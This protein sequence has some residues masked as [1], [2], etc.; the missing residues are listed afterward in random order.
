MVVFIRVRT[1]IWLATALVIFGAH[2]K[3]I[4]AKGFLNVRTVGDLRH[5]RA[6]TTDSFGFVWS[7]S[8]SGICRTDGNTW[9][10]PSSD[11]AATLGA[12]TEGRIWAAR[13]DGS[14]IYVGIAGP[15]AVRQSP[16]AGEIV[17]VVETQSGA[18]LV[19]TTGGLLQITSANRCAFDADCSGR[20][21]IEKPIAAMAFRNGTAVVGVG[22]ELFSIVGSRVDRIG[23]ADAPVTA[24]GSVG[25]DEW[26]FATCEPGSNP[27]KST[28]TYRL[29]G[30]KMVALPFAAPSSIR[31]IIGRFDIA[32]VATFG[33]G[34]LQLG[35]VS[36]DSVQ[37]E[38]WLRIS[39]LV[40]HEAMSTTLDWNRDLWVGTESGVSH[41]RFDYPLR[42]FTRTDRLPAG[43]IFSLA[44]GTDG[45]IWM[46]TSDGVS[47]WQRHKRDNHGVGVFDRIGLAE[48]LRILDIR[49]VAL[50]G[51]DVIIGGL[52]SGLFKV[53]AGPPVPYS[54]DPHF[55]RGVHSLRARKAGG[56]WVAPS[57][58]GLGWVQ[59]GKWHAATELE[60]QTRNLIF[61]LAETSDGD[62][63]LAFSRGGVARIADGKIR[64]F[65]ENLADIEMLA[66]LPI[67][68][69]SVLVGTKGAGLLKLHGESTDQV[70]VAQGLP[71][72]SIFGLLDDGNGRIWM[73]TPRGISAVE[74]RTLDKAFAEPRFR[75]EPISLGIRD[76]VPGEPT[77]AFFQ[78]TMK[79]QDGTLWFSTIA[80][81]VQIDPQAVIDM[82]PL[83]KPMG[84][85]RRSIE[86]YRHGAL[87]GTV[88]ICH[89][90][91]IAFDRKNER[92]SWARSSRLLR[93]SHRG[94]SRQQ[95][96]E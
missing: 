20:V 39:G 60:A 86:R 3:A 7:A 2:P 38:G 77:R 85:A 81:L 78:S 11:L 72:M 24:I 8:A 91:D 47:I 14:L 43:S 75:M 13:S 93:S 46:A 4:H 40:H 48:G 88:G 25:S 1:W 84:T 67:D 70:T 27:G 74:G 59:D 22:P 87:E 71:D 21:L 63:W 17:G 30:K 26:M 16:M 23:S 5:V 19:A 34:L 36:T 33:S 80:G 37:R 35:D 12:S 29:I 69:N 94:I 31:S 53:Q 10:C 49:S 42:S 50:V 32:F 90:N 68:K 96:P 18:L 6:L 9:V 55:Q 51:D 73:T 62:V 89:T 15:L 41:V 58:G 54:G 82:P 57:A 52:A 28:G 95:Y 65:A 64:R 83:H 92:T 76:G 44:E 79:S 45:R 66:L 61:D 56:F